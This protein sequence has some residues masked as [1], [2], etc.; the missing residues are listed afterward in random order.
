MED[1]TYYLYKNKKLKSIKLTTQKE[2]LHV[3]IDPQLFCSGIPSTNPTFWGLI[4]ALFHFKTI[5]SGAKN[6]NT[7]PQPRALC[8]DGAVMGAISHGPTFICD[9]YK[10]LTTDLHMAQLCYITRSDED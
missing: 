7:G 4:L 2:F 9:F 10:S 6:V 3:L 5:Q 1:Q 8:R